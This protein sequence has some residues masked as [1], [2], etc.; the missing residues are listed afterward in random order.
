PWKL[1]QM[2]ADQEFCSVSG[3]L[4][5][6]TMSTQYEAMYSNLELSEWL[7]PYDHLFAI[8]NVMPAACSGFPEPKKLEALMRQHNVP[9]VALNPR[10]N[11]WDWNGDHSQPLLKWL[12]KKQILAVVARSEVGAYWELDRFLEK[13]PK[14]QMLMVHAGWPEQHYVLPLLQKH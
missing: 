9:A 6:S 4:V 1:S 12:E 3:T 13:H 10:A 2:L 5:Q 14:L 11:G 7:K 8:W